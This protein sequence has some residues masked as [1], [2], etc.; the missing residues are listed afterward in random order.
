MNARSPGDAFRCRNPEEQ[1]QPDK[2]LYLDG[3][4]CL[5]VCFLFCF[6]FC[7]VLF[8]FLR[9][10]TGSWVAKGGGEDLGDR[11]ERIQANDVG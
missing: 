9:K 6:C 11:E 1:T 2:A 3:F 5:F 8:C 10:R 4:F 7:F